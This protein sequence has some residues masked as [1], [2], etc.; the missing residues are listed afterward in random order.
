[1]SPIPTA[2]IPARAGSDTD[3]CPDWEGGSTP[4]GI[5][6]RGVETPANK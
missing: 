6:Q 2:S 3:K 5:N 1:M 4:H